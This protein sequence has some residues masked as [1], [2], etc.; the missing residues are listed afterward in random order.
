MSQ[1]PADMLSR[2]ELMAGGDPTWDLSRNDMAAIQFALDEVAASKRILAAASA[3]APAPADPARSVQALLDKLTY[4]ETMTF[5]W[6]LAVARAGAPEVHVPRA[7]EGG[8]R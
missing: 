2:L 3:V 8:P 5:N 7:E 4:D 6:L 1:S